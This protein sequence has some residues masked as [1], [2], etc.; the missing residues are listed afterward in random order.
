MQKITHD[1]D[2]LYELEHGL[3]SYMRGTE[4]GWLTSCVLLL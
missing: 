3:R 1:L 4:V 2:K